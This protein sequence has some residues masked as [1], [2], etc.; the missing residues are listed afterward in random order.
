LFSPEG[1]SG[2][3]GEVG[4]TGI[5]AD[6]DISSLHGAE[7]VQVCLGMWQVQLRFHDGVSVSV[8]GDWQLLDERGV[9]IDQ[10]SDMVREQPFQLHRLL[11][12]GV[13]ATIVDAPLSFSLM[14]S[15]NLVFRVTVRDRGYECCSIEPLGIIL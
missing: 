4:V 13:T 8:E 12:R 14:F 15:G 2:L 1:L 7:V 9:M 6:L 5:P 3:S 10:S 11:G